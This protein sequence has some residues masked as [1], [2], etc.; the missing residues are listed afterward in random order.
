MNK[1]R[2]EKL[3]KRA[4]QS[5]NEKDVEYFSAQVAALANDKEMVCF[6][7]ARTVLEQKKKKGKK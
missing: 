6:P 7:V 4:E 2:A 1:E 5:G 3:L